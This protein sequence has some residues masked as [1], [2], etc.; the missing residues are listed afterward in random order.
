MLGRLAKQLV[1]P[2]AHSAPEQLTGRDG[3]RRAPEDVVHARRDAPGS[4]GMKQDSARVLRFVRVVFVEQPVAR[5]SWR[6]QLRQFGPQNLHLFVIQ[7]LHA[8]EIAVLV[9]ERDLLV[10]QPVLVPLTTGLGKPNEVSHQPVTL[11]QIG[12]HVVFDKEVR[13]AK[14]QSSRESEAP[15]E[16]YTRLKHPH[17]NGLRG[18]AGFAAASN[19]TRSK[20]LTIPT[21]RSPS[22]T[23]TR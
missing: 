13:A 6:R 1:V 14:V 23:T 20:L 4:K 12:D 22:T 10:A 17:L 9:P 5:V 2:E 7:D 11:R 15:A 19:L 21:G 18:Y 16:P 3:K 8:G